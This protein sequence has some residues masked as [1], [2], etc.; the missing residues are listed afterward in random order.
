MQIPLLDLKREYEFLKSDI[1]AQ[2]QSC[3]AAQQW[4]LGPKVAEFEEKVA[5]YLKVKSAAG[6][7]SGTDALIVAL[8]ALALR[9]K[10]K[11]F[12]DK[13]DE[14]ITTPFTF[15]AT[16]EAIVRAG[17]TPVFVDIDPDTF[18]IA[19]EAVKA[20]VTKNTV[21]IIPVHLYGLACDMEAI[22]GIAAENGLFVLEDTAQAFGAQ[23][24]AQGGGKGK[25]AGTMG[26]LG[27]FSFFP[28]KNLGGCGDG[29]GI[30]T[31]NQELAETVKILRNHG[32]RKKYDADFIG[33]N[34]RL[35][36]IQAAILLA[37]LDYI[38]KFNE[39]RRQAAGQYNEAFRRIKQ[40]Q[41]PYEPE[42]CRHVYHLYTIKVSSRRDEFLKYLNAQGITS[43]I[44]YPVLLNKMKAF[45][46]SRIGVPLKNTEKV[47]SEVLTLPLHPF[48]KEEE[49]GYVIGKVRNFF[50]S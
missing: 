38:D 45:R 41:T 12:F 6:V 22:L 39:D 23:Y 7:A 47:L 31:N 30:A 34:S 1:D 14:I 17:A 27:A 4:I 36:S 5:G 19:P 18:N 49:I 9:L 35:D 13:E 44:Y 29:G 8:S 46:D 43:R 11:E 25:R 37:R 40:I 26:D 2:L 20:A 28:S 24:S 21:G 50:N 42:N 48:L 3:F 10:N 15:V 32:Q 16:A 33:Y